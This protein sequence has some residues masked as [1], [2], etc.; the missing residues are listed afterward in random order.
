MQLV[1]EEQWQ[2]LPKAA[3]RV[4]A[5]DVLVTSVWARRV[6]P[7]AGVAQLTKLNIVTPAH[8][9]EVGWAHGKKADKKDE[10]RLREINLSQFRYLTMLRCHKIS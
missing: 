8:L 6:S 1:K 4:L 10:V 2:G 3:N 9:A 5:L 7:R